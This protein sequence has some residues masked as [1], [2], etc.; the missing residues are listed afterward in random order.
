M[1]MEVH[2][3]DYDS[4]V[5]SVLGI[6]MNYH[7]LVYLIAVFIGF[8]N[9]PNTQGGTKVLEYGM[10]GKVNVRSQDLKLKN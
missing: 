4:K 8:C 2:N 7:P 5:A 9:V 3:M 10:S 6:M 1:V